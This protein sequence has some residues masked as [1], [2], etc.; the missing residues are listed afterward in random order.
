MGGGWVGSDR[1]H[2]HGG[3][4]LSR[5]RG[6]RRVGHH[7]DRRGRLMRS[8]R[9]GRRGSRSAQP[10]RY[11]SLLNDLSSTMRERYISSQ[12]KSQVLFRNTPH[13]NPKLN[14]LRSF[15]QYRMAQVKEDTSDRVQEWKNLYKCKMSSQFERYMLQLT[16]PDDNAVAEPF[17]RDIVRHLE[18]DDGYYSVKVG[19]LLFGS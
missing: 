10:S 4:S 19:D 7:P 1:M 18:Y 12:V 15:G 14:S 5:S 9:N 11:I 6:R 16:W 8:S 3:D 13:A 2:N 17:V